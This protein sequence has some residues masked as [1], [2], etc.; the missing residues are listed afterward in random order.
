[1]IY[2]KKIA[3]IAY[4]PHHIHKAWAESTCDNVYKYTLST[5]KNG[6]NINFL[7]NSPILNQ[8]FSF[9]KGFFIPMYDVFLCEGVATMLPVIL[10]K[11][12][13]KKIKCVVINSDTFFYNLMNSKKIS[14]IFLK[15]V[16]N[17][18]GM[19][20]TSYYMKKQA[21][22]FINVPH[23]VVYPWVDYDK[24][25]HISPKLN[26]KKIG[27]FTAIGKNKGADIMIDTFNI[28]RKKDKKYNLILVGKIEEKINTNFPGINTVGFVPPQEMSKYFNA[29]GSYLNPARNEP[30]GVNILEAMATGI[31]PLVSDCCGAAEIVSKVSKDLITSTDPK[32]IASRL[33]WLDDDIE[34]KEKLGRKCRKIASKYTKEASVKSFQKEFKKTVNALF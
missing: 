16:K 28:I 13:N 15:Y 4:V 33:L 22:Q 20:S 8:A 30:F 14:P 31:P 26:L 21:E 12:I 25:S 23:R 19:I 1:M 3:F 6:R 7:G 24:F 17:I 2:N 18:D 5:L 9:F 32:E 11:K 10:K 29:I 34:Y 27:F